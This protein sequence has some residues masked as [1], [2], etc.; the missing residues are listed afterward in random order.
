MIRNLIKNYFD[1]SF[2]KQNL[3]FDK[4]NYYNIIN[5]FKHL[6]FN[7]I[8]FLLFFIVNLYWFNSGLIFF[9]SVY[10]IHHD[11]WTLIFQTDSIL[12]KL[13]IYFFL[14]P[15][16]ISSF[17]HSISTWY[18]NYILNFLL[19]S[20]N[21]N[22]NTNFV[23]YITY[24]TLLLSKFEDFNLFVY[25]KTLLI[26]FDI[27]QI[28]L[29]F[30][31]EYP[32]ILLTGL[33]FLFTTIFSLICLSYLGLY[34]VFIL[35]LASI[36]LF[37]LSMLYYFN[38]IV[39]ENYYYYIS[40][41]KWMYLSNGFRVSFDLLIDLTSISFSFL[42]L[43]I[44]VFVY[45]YTFSYFRYEPLVERL[46]LFLNSFM[47]SMILLVSSGNFIVLF[48]GWE[49]IGLTSFFLINFWSTRVGTLKAAFKAFSFN[50]L[51]DL[52]LF[53]A[54]LII[55]STTYNL[56]ILSFNNQIYLYESYNIDMFYWSINLIEI[57]SFFFI[58]C[59]FIKSAQFGAHIWLPD[60]MEAPVPAS[61]LI[62]SA[63][64]VSAGIYLLLRLSPL[65]ELSKYAYF[66][67]PLIGSV[68]A[69]YGGLVSAFQSDTK[70]TLA[71]STIS[72]CGF[73]MVSYST[74][75]LEFVILYLYVH[76]FFKAATFLCVGNVNR[77][78]RNIQDFKRM[79]GFYKYLP[80]EC[81][82][83]FVCMINL[84][85]LPLTL[86]FYIKHLLFIGLVESYT[87]YPL[88]FS[89]LILG[90]IAGVFYSYRLF[91]SIFFDTKKGKKAIYLQASRIILNSKFYSNTS[92]ASNLSITF[93]VLISYTVILYL[94]CT[95][96]N[97][98][99]SLSD[100][101]SI[102]INN[103][104]SY[105]YKPDYNFLNAVSIL[106]WFVIILLISVIYLNWRWSYY[107][108][109]SI[110]SLSKF[111]LF[112]FFFFIFSKYIL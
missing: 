89:S 33:L 61:A 39:S 92:L 45:I 5:I 35:N 4:Y 112:S 23:D 13:K 70:K 7:S 46:I 29:D 95:T 99:Y 71:Y 21:L 30:L 68:T 66:I 55:F 25:I 53:F 107:Y 6:N 106:N 65:F 36:L 59:A 17:I 78:N 14:L 8:L 96:L 50:K 34:G 42:T 41:G 101:K 40:L 3:N 72:H 81:L 105:F 100:L 86:G 9:N 47:I 28:N 19:F 98:Y 93:L 63:T 38:L 62:H 109:K 110:D 56:D 69:F 75:V 108:T 22:T 104:Y 94:Y 58:S 73:L 16:Y 74:G 77:F 103:A 18:Y 32:I 57:I 11:A 37:W 84:S 102:Y 87:L 52:F 88:I 54:I 91:Y 51:S 64:L 27:R 90:A 26:T 24:N 44:G 76:G 20:E 97:N 43:T 1:F 10:K 2:K 12:N 111:I 83:S 48:L 79:G 60:S 85:G 80:F 49:L 15:L 67:L 31:N 82:A